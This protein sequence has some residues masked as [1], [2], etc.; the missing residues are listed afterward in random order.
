MQNPTTLATLLG[1]LSALSVQALEPL[2]ESTDAFAELQARRAIERSDRD[3][4]GKI[5]KAEDEGRWKRMARYDKNKDEA[6]DLD[7]LKAMPVVHLDSPGKKLR[8]V[9][10]KRTEQGPVFLDFYFPDDDGRSDKPLVIYTH[11]G[12]WAA[13][14]KS[15]AGMNSFKVVHR[16]LLKKGFC[17]LSVDYR[18]ATDGVTMRDCVVDSMDALRFASAHRKEL[19]IDPERVFTFGDSA[20]GHLAQMVLLAPPERFEGDAELAKFPFKTAAGVSWYGPCDF[21]DPDLFN[22]STRFH[23]RIV[24]GKSKS[25]DDNERFS[26]VSPIVYLRKESPPLLMLQGDKDTTIPVKQAYQM[27]E[28]LKDIKAPVEIVIVKN[29]GHN[30][31][32]VDG[33]VTPNR[34]QIIERTIKFLVENQ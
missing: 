27:Q 20:G 17:V 12:G 8:D 34:E 14:S 10:F 22:G 4:D 26:E 1:I 7:E 33:E 25:D 3:G 2:K 18:L 9:I 16:E 31:R 6:L 28:A 32:P 23:G 21:R 30:W 19:G 11:G 5:Q 24:G 29:A 13:G 15:G